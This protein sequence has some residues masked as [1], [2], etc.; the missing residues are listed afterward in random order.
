M[1][2]QT[3]ES[4]E[5]ELA[6]CHALTAAVAVQVGC[7]LDEVVGVRGTFIR[8]GRT[9]IAL[10]LPYMHTTS[11]KRI[12]LVLR[13]ASQGKVP[14]AAISAVPVKLYARDADSAQVLV[15]ESNT[16]TES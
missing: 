8:P 16:Y 14:C 1:H 7:A 6:P 4:C 10:F 15:S 5:R 12:A 2:V 9:L 13:R 3:S 11:Q